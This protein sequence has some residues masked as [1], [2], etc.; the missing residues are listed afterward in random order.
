[1]KAP[2]TGA[3][4]FSVAELLIA[5]VISGAMLLVGVAES[6]RALG[7]QQIEHSLRRI[8]IGLEQG[9]EAARRSGRPCALSLGGQGWQAPASGTLPA[10]AGVALSLGEGLEPGPLR[11]RLS[12]E[13]NL[14]PLVRFSSNGLVLDGGTVL[15]S[16]EGDSLVRCLVMAL[17]LGVVRLGQHSEAGCRPDTAL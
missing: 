7:R 1:M 5:V 4:G 9:R 13:H 12:L 8:L 6:Q 17:P 15:I 11:R 14:P 2:P 16:A 3:R 10:C